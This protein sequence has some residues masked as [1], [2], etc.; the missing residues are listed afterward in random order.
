[1][2]WWHGQCCYRNP[3]GPIV[4]GCPAPGGYAAEVARV[5]SYLRFFWCTWKCEDDDL[6]CRS[7]Q[8]SGFPAHSLSQAGFAAITAVA[9]VPALRRN[10][11]WVSFL[12]QRKRRRWDFWCSS[13]ERSTIHFASWFGSRGRLC[14]PIF[15]ASCAVW[16]SRFAVARSASGRRLTAHSSFVACFCRLMAIFSEVLRFLAQPFRGFIWPQP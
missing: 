12:F 8:D 11:R 9:G 15:M 5:L 1:L 10:G 6:L 3:L 14:L 13:V 7:R 4:Q 16:G 2:V